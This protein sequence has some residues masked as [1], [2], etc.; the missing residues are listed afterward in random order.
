MILSNCLIILA[1]ISISMIMPIASLQSPIHSSSKENERVLPSVIQ[2]NK[3]AVYNYV[4]AYV[5]REWLVLGSNDGDIWTV[6]DYEN[7]PHCDNLLKVYHF[8]LNNTRTAYKQYKITIIQNKGYFV[9]W[10]PEFYPYICNEGFE[11][12]LYSLRHDIQQYLMK[13]TLHSSISGNEPN[14]THFEIYPALPPTV[15]LDPHTGDIYGFFVGI[16]FSI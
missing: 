13:F 15:T 2:L 8:Q 3:Y 7:D 16:R 10:L 4:F 9:T 11:E 1:S 12:P 6:L 5:P 14:S